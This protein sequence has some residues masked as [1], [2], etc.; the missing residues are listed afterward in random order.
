MKGDEKYK[1]ISNVVFYDY[2]ILFEVLNRIMRVYLT[3]IEEY[4]ERTMKN[5]LLNEEKKRGKSNQT[6]S[7]GSPF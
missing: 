2:G 6:L 1:V 7:I 4:R 5:V 3:A